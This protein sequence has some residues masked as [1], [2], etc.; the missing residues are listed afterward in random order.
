MADQDDS[1]AGTFVNSAA[2]AISSAARGAARLVGVPMPG[3]SEFS[4]DEEKAMRAPPVIVRS[5]STRR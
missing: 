3:P 4:A 2:G 1:F 5:P